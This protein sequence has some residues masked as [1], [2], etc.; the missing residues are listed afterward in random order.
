[1]AEEEREAAA[2][3]PA[4]EGELAAIV[5]TQDMLGREAIATAAL[6]FTT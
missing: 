3:V 1:M 2:L 4:H 5:K 6:D